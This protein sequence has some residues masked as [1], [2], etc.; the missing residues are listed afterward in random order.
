VVVDQYTSFL[1]HGEHANDAACPHCGADNSTWLSWMAFIRA[2]SA[3]LTSRRT[4]A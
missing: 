3:T 1:G 2:R 4:G